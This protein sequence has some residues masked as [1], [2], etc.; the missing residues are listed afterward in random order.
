MNSYWSLLRRGREEDLCKTLCGEEAAFAEGH[1]TCVP[2]STSEFWWIPSWIRKRGRQITDAATHQKPVECRRIFHFF[3]SCLLLSELH[4]KPWKRRR[5]TARKKCES[6]CWETWTSANP[7]SNLRRAF[8]REWDV[9]LQLFLRLS[10]G[11]THHFP[12]FSHHLRLF[13]TSQS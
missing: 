6:L 12:L 8:V 10:S 2:L 5:R 1:G 13:F 3:S 9:N 11:F 7:V 4:L